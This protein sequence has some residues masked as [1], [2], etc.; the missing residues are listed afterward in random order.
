MALNAA[1]SGHNLV[2]TEQTDLRGLRRYGPHKS[3]QR[4][5]LSAGFTQIP[6]EVTSSY[7]YYD[8]FPF[9]PT[10]TLEKA[11]Q[12]SVSRRRKEQLVREGWG[13][14]GEWG[15]GGDMGGGKQCLSFPSAALA[16]I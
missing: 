12:V 3:K 9:P 2:M 14:T 10:C 13:W 8:F 1:A 4:H 6:G 7:F 16:S 5:T 15:G 11:R